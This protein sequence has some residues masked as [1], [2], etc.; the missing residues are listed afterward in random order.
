M[1][2]PFGVQLRPHNRWRGFKVLRERWIARIDTSRLRPVVLSDEVQEMQPPVL[3]ELRIL[4][5]SN[6]D[7]RSIVTVD[8]RDRETIDSRAHA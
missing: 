6:F 1:G 7:S 4:S 5:S 2:D 3:S 8:D